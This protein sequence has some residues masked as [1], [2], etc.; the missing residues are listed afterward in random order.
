MWKARVKCNPSFGN[1]LPCLRGSHSVKI[2]KKFRGG[3]LWV[4]VK[5]HSEIKM[6]TYGAKE[7]LC[8]ITHP[9]HTLGN[10]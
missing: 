3:T 5:A 4:F 8:V 10:L 9:L 6:P 2:D 1:A 7:I